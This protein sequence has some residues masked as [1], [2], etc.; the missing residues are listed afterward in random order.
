MT[1]DIGTWF[2]EHVPREWFTGPLDVRVDREEILVVGVL[3][4]GIDPRVFREHSREARMRL[5][6]VAE[7]PP[8]RARDQCH[9]DDDRDQKRRGHGAPAARRQPPRWL[10]AVGCAQAVRAADWIRHRVP[11]P[12]GLR[13]FPAAWRRSPQDNA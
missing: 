3:A 10:H 5:A 8:C 4:P 6:A 12:P 1:S 13:G 9:D 11:P 2:G 7:E